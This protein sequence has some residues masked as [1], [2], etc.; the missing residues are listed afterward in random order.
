MWFGK[1]GGSVDDEVI[2]TFTNMNKAWKEKKNY[3][4]IFT[5]GTLLKKVGNK[6]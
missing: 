3:E 6:S 1:L 5:V 2:K 4:E